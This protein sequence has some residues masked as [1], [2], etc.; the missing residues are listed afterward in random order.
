MPVEFKSVSFYYESRPDLAVLQDISFQIEQGKTVAL[1]GSSGAGKSTVAGL[2]LRFFEPQEGQILLGN[3]DIAQLSL[4]DWRNYIALVPQEVF[5]FG[6]TIEENIAYGKP[7]ASKEEIWQ[8]VEKANMLDFIERFPD[9]LQ[10]IVGDRGIQLSGGQKQR[11]AIAR[12]ILKD[13]AILILDEATSSLDT[14]SEKLVQ[15]ALEQLMQ[16]RTSII[17]AHRLTTIKNADQIFVLDK[18]KIAE[19]GTHEELIKKQGMYYQLNNN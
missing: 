14:E 7:T 2:M 5:L 18:G 10:T 16:N 6:G 17:I 12:A 3:Q 13:P 11:V 8:A 9:G 1:V 19:Q 4:A 15:H